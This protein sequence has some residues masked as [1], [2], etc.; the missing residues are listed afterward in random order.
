MVDL[1]IHPIEKIVIDSIESEF[2]LK[3]SDLG[4]IDY[5]YNHIDIISESKF[6]PEIISTIFAEIK[7]LDEE[8]KRK[9]KDILFETLTIYNDELNIQHLL[10]QLDKPLE[11]HPELLTSCFSIFIEQSKNK[12][13]N[14]IVRAWLLEAA[15]RISLI[16]KSVRFKLLAVLIDISID[17]N[18]D[19]LRHLSKILGLCYSIW[20]E[21]ELV[22]K[23]EKIKH[24]DKGEDEVWFELG[25]C[26]L[27]NALK[28][29]SKKMAVS[30][31]SKAKDHFEKSILLE[32]ERPDA[33][34]YD[35]IISILLAI[36][37]SNFKIDLSH[38]VEE[39]K[40]AIH[41]YF[42]WHQYYE[43]NTWINARNTEMNNWFVLISKLE[44]LLIHLDEK[45]WFEPKT[46]I[47]THLLNIYTASRTILKKNELGGL[48]EIIQ[49]KIEASLVA[50]SS[51]LYVLEKWLDIN[52]DSELGAV[53][54]KLRREVKYSQNKLSGSLLNLAP[55][56]NELNVHQKDHFENFLMDYR[57]SQTNDVSIHVEAIFENC[58][59]TLI[60]NADYNID[61]IKHKFNILL[62]L[63]IKFLE[64][65]MNV[66]QQDFPYLSYLFEQSTKPKEEKL[67]ND[68]YQFMLT[69]LIDGETTIERS[70]I[71]SG[72]VDVY[73]SFNRFHVS[74]EIKRDWTDCSFEAIR[75]NYLGQAAEYSNT[76]VK[77]GFLLVLDL[78]LKPKGVKS[79]ES[80]VK[81][82]VIQK[83]NDPIDRSIVVIIVPGMRKTPSQVKSS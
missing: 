53:A 72:R 31:F 9:A 62:F 67:Q 46:V 15:F 49:P 83:Q 14:P 29:T 35:A 23:L 18:N 30:Y 1:T 2:S 79:I 47:E 68:Y 38:Y 56:L 81:V 66:T 77:L 4:D 36:S 50:N 45:S 12:K 37:K 10:E 6:A 17:D 70:N 52:E 26:Y 13:K 59:Q 75:K 54:E 5:L 11:L 41:L 76:D 20:Q 43:N 61:I 34:A 73:F 80:S 25:M 40:K 22:E 69:S 7:N 32:I 55:S 19:Y 71:A 51:Q 39:T 21:N 48:E 16:K 42:S 60:T 3:L 24:A 74:A 28:A 82:E 58:V 27:L 44:S 64:S 78:T 65:R 57:A 33:V 63:S 8:Q